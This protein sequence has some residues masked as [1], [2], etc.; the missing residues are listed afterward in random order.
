MPTPYVVCLTSGTG[1]ARRKMLLVVPTSFN[2]LVRNTRRDVG[3]ERPSALAGGL[4]LG[5]DPG[6]GN[7]RDATDRWRASL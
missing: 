5:S 6:P 7:A 4:G 2:D 1:F 3:I